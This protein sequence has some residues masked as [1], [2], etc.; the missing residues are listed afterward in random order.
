VFFLC[1]REGDE[2]Y[3]PKGVA[4]GVQGQTFLLQEKKGVRFDAEKT[5]TVKEKRHRSAHSRR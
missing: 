1:A 5:T 3:V 4:N 2:G